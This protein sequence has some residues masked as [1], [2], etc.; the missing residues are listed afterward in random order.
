MPCARSSEANRPSRQAARGDIPLPDLQGLAATLI[1]SVDPGRAE[2]L[3]R[4]ISD[5][6]YQRAALGKLAGLIAVADFNRAERLARDIGD[7][8]LQTRALKE[9]AKSVAGK[10]PDRAEQI[11]RCIHDRGLQAWALT[12]VAEG[13]LTYLHGDWQELGELD[14]R[15]AHLL[16][17]LLTGLAI[18]TASDCTVPAPMRC[19]RRL[20][21][22]VTTVRSAT[23]VKSLRHL[24][25]AFEAIA[26]G[27]FR[28]IVRASEALAFL[29][30]L[31]RRAVPR[32]ATR[33]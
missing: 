23:R 20:R 13:T 17:Q 3:V 24:G 27:S 14:E 33:L 5:V 31:R 11:A 28:L 15:R 9:V 1:A 30:P 25:A 16:T 4:S 12:A 19:L 7:P 21:Y 29:R 22:C 8:V 6:I 18:R 2:R 10:D 26:V 32:K